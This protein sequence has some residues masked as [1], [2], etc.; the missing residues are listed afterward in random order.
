M[1]Q[2]GGAH[3]SEAGLISLNRGALK[4]SC[5]KG[6]SL[7][8]PQE[9]AQTS[10][11]ISVWPWTHGVPCLAALTF[12]FISSKRVFCTSLDMFNISINYVFHDTSGCP[13][14]NITVRCTL[15]L[16]I[17]LYMCYCSCNFV[18]KSSFTYNFEIS[19]CLIVSQNYFDRTRECTWIIFY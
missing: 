2:G 7:A 10:S 17:L 11:V 13:M 16:E 12:R 5:M 1:V 15:C 8:A 3:G 9:E 18:V 6:L 4:S 19:E 14:R